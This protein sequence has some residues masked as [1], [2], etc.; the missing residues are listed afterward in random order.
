MSILFQLKEQTIWDAFFLRQQSQRKMTPT[1]LQEL[2]EFISERRYLKIAD[3]IISGEAFSLP[4]KHLV[5]KVSSQKKRT[6]YTFSKEESY[7]LKVLA[8]LLYA[9]DDAFPKNLY[10]F[11]KNFGVKRALFDLTNGRN[12]SEMYSYKVDV[13]NYFNSVD[14][15]ICLS[16]LREIITDDPL[17]L[18]FISRILREDRVIYEESIISESHGIMAGIPISSF[19]ANVYLRKLD[20]FFEQNRILY[21]RYSDDII[22]FAPSLEE[23]N[24][25]I[26]AIKAFLAK[27]KLG[28]NPQKEVYTNPGEPCI[29]LGFQYS[30]GKTDIS[31]ISLEKVKAKLRRKARALLRWKRKK[32]LDNIYAVKGFINFLN[33]YFYSNDRTEEMTWS[34]WFFPIIT[35]DESLKAIDKYALEQIRYIYSEKHNKSN[36]NLRYS[37]IKELKYKP[38]VSAY[39]S[40]REENE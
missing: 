26:E 16:E 35:T 7:V 32:E 31:P 9:Y 5:N 19:L 4:T 10:S 3:A 6:V 25:H 38:L 15:E 27:Y 37:E 23:L 24:N 30:N 39:Y 33:R 40:H 11:R 17:L 8:Q 34:R 22:V 20:M 21:A 29:F 2:S 36:Y 13:S 12:I 18:D 14:I 1:E 28:V